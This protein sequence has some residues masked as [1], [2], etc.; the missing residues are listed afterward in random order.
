MQQ[1]SHYY[2]MNTTSKNVMYITA[3]LKSMD[4][5]AFH[6]TVEGTSNVIEFF[7]APEQEPAFNDLLKWL[8]ECRLEF[9]IQ[10]TANRLA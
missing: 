7:V 3:L 9:S 6:R 4:N 1:L 10:Q 2:L 5:V 8:K